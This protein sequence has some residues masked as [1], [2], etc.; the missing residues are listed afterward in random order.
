MQCLRPRRALGQGP[1]LQADPD[2]SGLARNF[3]EEGLQMSGPGTNRPGIIHPR[4]IPVAV[5]AAAGGPLAPVQTAPTPP[6]PV[7]GCAWAWF[8]A[9]W[10]TLPRPLVPA[11]TPDAAAGRHEP[12]AHA[13]AWAHALPHAL[14]WLRGAAH[15]AH[16][17]RAASRHAGSVHRP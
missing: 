13:G 17:A 2:A 16:A 5:A 15:A 3:P 8:A 1:D 11:R 4:L 6:A 10:A 9:L 14:H 12:P 7:S